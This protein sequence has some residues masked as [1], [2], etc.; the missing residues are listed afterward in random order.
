MEYTDLT[1]LL[2]AGRNKADSVS[3]P[4]ALAPEHHAE[5]EAPPVTGC[6]ID[7]LYEAIMASLIF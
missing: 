4:A 7:K 2:A 6:P 1:E 5:P 3:T